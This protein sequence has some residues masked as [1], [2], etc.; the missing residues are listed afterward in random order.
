LLPALAQDG[1]QFGQQNGRQVAS[2]VNNIKVDSSGSDNSPGPASTCWA[3]LLA[4]ALALASVSARAQQT[5]HTDSQAA[6]SNPASSPTFGAYAQVRVCTAQDI[7]AI[8]TPCPNLAT[9]SDQFGNTLSLQT[10]QFGQLKTDAIGRYNFKCPAGTNLW[11]QIEG[12]NSASPFSAYAITC[13]LNSVVTGLNSLVLNNTWSDTHIF[14]NAVTFQN[15]GTSSDDFTFSSNITTGDN[16]TFNGTSTFVGA[17]AAAKI[18][19]TVYATQFPGSDIFAQANAA[20]AS[21]AGPGMV[22][23]PPGVYN[24]VTTTL[25]GGSGIM[26]SAYGATV[27]FTAT[28]GNAM[29]FRNVV[30]SGIMGL[31]LNGPNTG[32]TVALYLGSGIANSGQTLYNLFSDLQIGGNDQTVLSTGFFHGMQCDGNAG[33]GTYSNTFRNVNIYASLGAQW[34]LSPT[35]EQYCNANNFIGDYAE[36]GAADGVYLNGAYGN[37]FVGFRSET[38]AGYGF[39]LG[40]TVGTNNNQIIGGW[41]ESNALGDVN[42]GANVN[43]TQM[44]GT[45]LASS[46]TSIL[47]DCLNPTPSVAGNVWLGGNVAANQS[48]QWYGWNHTYT[49]NSSTPTNKTIFQF[50]NSERPASGL[51]PFYWFHAGPNSGRLAIGSP[52]YPAT[53]QTHIN[54]TAPKTFAGACSM[55]STTTCSFS[56]A[57]AYT[58]PPLCFASVQSATPTTFQGSCALSGT[59][60][61]ITASA[62]NTSTWAA[63]LIGDPN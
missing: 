9:T 62:A 14:Q 7:G 19:N 57:N 10:G 51:E 37:T 41:L 5:V 1:S 52:E 33:A 3:H 8:V 20:A 4:L 40:A 53:F 32:T 26:F 38:N 45:N 25:H 42:C 60:V 13:P 22:I 27:N 46:P 39:N 58:V 21:L 61:T 59:T 55:S 34:Y 44:F 18:N 30:N 12:A 54:Q 35:A 23:I 43:N 29:L 63:L 16:W 31:T 24:A 11:V 6:G 50:T 28:S 49:V 2:P 47:A 17:V 56:I 48:A 15:T 36:H